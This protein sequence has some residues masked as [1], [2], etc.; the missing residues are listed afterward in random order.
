MRPTLIGTSSRSRCL[1]MRAEQDKRIQTM[2]GRPPL[3]LIDPPDNQ[4]KPRPRSRR[5]AAEGI[6]NGRPSFITAVHPRWNLF[7][8]V[9]DASA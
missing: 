9:G 3:A 6:G 8:L 1:L 4:R 7:S 2:L 5:S